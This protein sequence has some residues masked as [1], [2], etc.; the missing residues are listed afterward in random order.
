[1]TEEIKIKIEAAKE[2]A[3]FWAQRKA[4]D[5]REWWRDNKE[6]VIIL[7]PIVVGGLKVAQKSITR[8][9]DAKARED[10]VTKR[11]WDPRLGTWYELRRPL[12]NSQR[13]KLEEL[14]ADG[15]TTGEALHSLGVLK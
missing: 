9:A 3:A 15:Y 7:A 5:F 1:M 4:E 2:K 10:L 6:A 12:N 13:L 11:V 14:K 8:H